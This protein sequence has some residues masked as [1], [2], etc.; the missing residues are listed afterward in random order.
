MED[1]TSK[2]EEYDFVSLKDDRGFKKDLVKFFSGGRYQMS[3]DEM[4]EK[5]FDGLTKDFVEHMRGQSWNEVTAAKDYNYVTNKDLDDSGKQAFGRLMTAW[6]NSESVGG[7]FGDGAGDFAEAILTAPSTYIGLGSFG[8]GKVAAKIGSKGTQILVRRAAADAIKKNTVKNTL[9]R[10]VMKEGSIGA[11]TGAIT[12]GGQSYLQGETREEVIG[13]YN[14]STKDLLT[15]AAIG[16]ALG[17]VL[18]SVSGVIGRGREKTVDGILESRKKIFEEEAEVAAEA[19]TL[20]LSKVDAKTKKEAFKLVAD[21]DDILSARAGVEGAKLKNKLDPE[22]VQKGKVL[23]AA[24]SDPKSTVPFDSG[25]STQT[26]RSIAAASVDVMSKLKVKESERISETIANAIRDGDVDGISTMLTDVR[27]KYGLSKDEFSLIYLAEAS[28]AGQTLGYVS[29]MSKGFKSKPDNTM[30]ILF[31]KGV[32]SLSDSQMQEISAAAV[33]NTSK[34]KKSVGFLRDLDALRISMMTSQPA[35]TMRN[36]RNSGILITTDMVDEVNKAMYKGLFQGDLKAIKDI[37]PNATALLRGYTFGNADAKLVRSLMMEEMPEQSRRLYNSAMRTEVM[38]E[39]TSRLAKTARFVNLANTASDSVLKEGMFYGSLDRQ[40]RDLDIKQSLSQWLR[41]NKKLEDLPEGISVDK[42]IEESNRLTMQ[43]DFRGDK[44]LLGSG[45]RGLSELNRKLPFVISGAMGVPFPRYLGNHLSMVADYIPLIGELGYRTGITS[46]AEDAAT[47]VS[48]Q[49][50]GLYGIVGGIALAQMRE[51]EVDYGSIKNE[52]G[53]QEDMKPYVGAVLAHLWLGDRIWRS[54]EGMPLTEG[55][56]FARELKDVLGG[57]PDFTFD[58]TIIEGTANFALTGEVTEEF[59]KGIGSFIS[60]FSMPFAVARDMVGQFDYDQA[61]APFVRDLANS[62]GIS[63][64]AAGGVDLNVLQMQ[65]SRMLPDL[66]FI[67]YTQSFNGETDLAYYRFSNPVAIGKMNPLIKQITGATSEPALTGL[68]EE[69]NKG[70]L[71]DWMLYNKRT[72]PNANLDYVVRQRLAKTM[73]KNFEVWRETGTGSK[74]FGYTPYDEIQDPKKKAELL[75][76][77]IK[78][79]ITTEVKRTEVMFD[80]YAAAS[81]VKARGFIRNN[82]AIKRKEVGK[83]VFDEAAKEFGYESAD[84][85][86]ADSET[87]KIEV[88][89]RMAILMKIN[90]YI[91]NEPY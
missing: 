48:R 87:V 44:S 15:D 36:I 81:P 51:G 5:G 77:W 84:K 29:A 68:E 57:I 24:L 59:E 40:F 73:S 35:T 39:G 22:R 45:A 2:S 62:E 16:G 25:L 58:T 66:E 63:T 49:M 4:K 67:Q 17:G 9:A 80:K 46:G 71:K 34:K 64:K 53:A 91:P 33:R 69:M 52:L 79:Q 18:G 72:V 70:N 50:T 56:A 3:A 47:R 23:L 21:I 19:A 28:R 88:D 74:Q 41:S 42:A 75:E 82:Y 86:I 32:S 60:T 12:E 8:L 31:D 7:T 83:D 76:G 26:M 54:S 89:R 43:R 20:T 85:F 1:Y 11:A 30:D 38:M 14:Y 6:D 55:K 78:K 13:G 61:G 27:K 65:S 10:S 90:D 37:I